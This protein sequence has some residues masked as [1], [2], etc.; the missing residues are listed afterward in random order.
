MLNIYLIGFMGSGKTTI[1]KKISKSLNLKFLDTDKEIEKKTRSSINDI[2]N[3]KGELFFRQ[4]EKKIVNEIINLENTVISTGGGLPCFNKNIDIL[5]K[6]G[7]TIYLKCDKELLYNR[8][9][10]DKKNRPLIKGFN[11][12]ELK[13]YINNLLIKREKIYNKSKYTIVCNDLKTNELLRQINSL[14][15]TK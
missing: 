5:N 11:H 10:V 4:E 13:K 12:K 3:K 1:A 14:I 8:L 2:F 9:L 7:C 15:F 6:S